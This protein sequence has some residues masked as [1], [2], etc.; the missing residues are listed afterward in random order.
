[1]LSF[2]NLYKAK[3]NCLINP[4]NTRNLFFLENLNIHMTF[5]FNSLTKIDNAFNVL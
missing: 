1:M 5:D 4:N 3:K 2:K